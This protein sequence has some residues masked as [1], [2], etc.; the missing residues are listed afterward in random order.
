MITTNSRIEGKK[1]S[2]L[3]LP[4]RLRT[5]SILKTKDM[6]ETF[7]GVQD[8]PYIIQEFALSGVR[9]ATRA[10]PIA[11]APYRLAPSEMHELSNQLQELAYRG[12]IQPSTLPW[13]A[14]VLFVKKKDRTFRMC[15]DYRELNKL[16]V[17]NHYPLP[18]I[19]D[20]FDNFKV[21]VFT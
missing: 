13:G 8:A 14:P 7:L 10:A 21:R 3:M 1:V 12:F 5:K 6:Q 15:I 11:R 16:T 20:L 18:R 17:K 19:D 4:P 2:G 9:L